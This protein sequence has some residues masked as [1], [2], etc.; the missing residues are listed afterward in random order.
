MVTAHGATWADT[1][2]GW[3]QTILD[4]ISKFMHAE[5]VRVL[6]ACKALAVPGA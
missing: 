3:V 6:N 4:S 1:Y 2:A 5:T